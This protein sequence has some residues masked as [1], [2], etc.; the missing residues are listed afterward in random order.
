MAKSVFR[1]N[2][3]II[4]QDT[5]SISSPTIVLKT[6][7]IAEEEEKEF[8]KAEEVYA[9]PTADDLR[10]EAEEFKLQW[11]AER[12]EM[13]AAAK[14][15][16]SGIVQAVNKAAEEERQKNS[17]AANAILAK[18]Q[19]DVKKILA[20]A[21]IKAAELE[22]QNKRTIDDER[23]EVFLQAKEAGRNDGY[24]E[25]RIEVDRLIERTHTV[26][27]RAQ[28]KRGEILAET[29]Q[30]I[31]DLVLL[32]A[33]KIVKVISEN[34]REV[35]VSNVTEALKKVKDKGNIIIRVNLSDVKLTTQHT[36]DFIKKLEGVKSI[37][38]M[39]DGSVDS[40][41][42]IIETDFGEIDARI[43]SQ[44]A[45]LEAKI[46]EITPIRSKVKAKK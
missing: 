16:A 37:Q 28:D 38:V 9:G 31:I 44:L 14:A 6:N 30:E 27:E 21:E 43:S 4:V 34:Q 20:D 25:G 5:F 32:V 3:L 42:C 17:E 1:P 2:E 23:Q 41:G 11:E 40:G 26:L 22:A 29:E 18:A 8:E 12:E 19:E 7:N 45:E 36:K 35:I 15:E 46:L 33:R 39:E 24:A 13:I 10:Q